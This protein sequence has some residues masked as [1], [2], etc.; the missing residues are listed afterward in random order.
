MPESP[1]HLGFLKRARE[2]S[3][4]AEVVAA[5]LAAPI[6]LEH[7][8]RREVRAVVAVARVVHL[9]VAAARPAARAAPPVPPLAVR[10]ALEPRAGCAVI[11]ATNHCKREAVEPTSWRLARRARVGCRV[12][13]VARAER[14]SA[15]AS[16]GDKPASCGV[17][18]GAIGTGRFDKRQRHCCRGRC[19]RQREERAC[20][21]H[22]GRR[23]R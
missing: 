7:F 11:G 3:I 19:E 15:L 16:T 13:L 12:T 21:Q 22:R 9:V 14:I 8:V 5:R 6:R 17:E 20:K 4:F 18:D 1:G 23:N 2:R 10:A